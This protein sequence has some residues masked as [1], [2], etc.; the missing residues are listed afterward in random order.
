MQ[1]KMV[2]ILQDYPEGVEYSNLHLC[3]MVKI[4]EIQ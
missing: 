2:E 4:L 3:L 1:K